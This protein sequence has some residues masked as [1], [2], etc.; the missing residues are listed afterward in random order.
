VPGSHSSHVSKETRGYLATRPGRFRYVHTPVH[1]SWLNPVEVAFSKM[2]RTFLRHIRVGSL[3]ELSRRILPGIREMNAAPVPFRW[4]S[5]D[6]LMSEDV[7]T[8]Q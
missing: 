4:K 8:N 3:D 5:F 6:S 1:A 2:P 7:T